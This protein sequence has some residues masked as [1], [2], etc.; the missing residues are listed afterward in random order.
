MTTTIPTEEVPLV[1]A[2]KHFFYEGKI[3]NGDLM[4]EYKKLTLAD[5]AEIKEGLEKNGYKIKA[6]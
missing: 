6:Y 1:S 4:K 2:I 5:R 3:E